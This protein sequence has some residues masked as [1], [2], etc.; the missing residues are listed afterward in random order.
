MTTLNRRAPLLA[1][2]VAAHA[3]CS[4]P[5]TGGHATPA[6]RSTR[7]VEGPQGPLYVDDGGAGGTAVLLVHSGA[8]STEHWAAQLAHLRRDRRAVALDVRGHGRSAPPRDGS[9][10]VPA[11]GEDVVAVADALG[12]RRFVLVGH[13]QGAAV[14]IAAAARAWERVLGLLLLDPATDGR[15]MPR[16]QAAG[17]LAALRSDAYPQL[18]EAYWREQLVGARPVV[19][20][21]VVA[22]LHATRREA[23]IGSL[24]ALLAFDPVTPLRG[25]AF[26]RR[27]VITRINER[28]DALH[29]LVPEISVERIE[30][31]GHWLQLD[32]PEAVNAALDRFLAAITA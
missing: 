31:T 22:D 15:A 2:A 3:A 27:S 30:G 12:I 13:S 7:L 29:A 1:A 16:D 11:M 24:E 28:P 26:P 20:S 23:V 21:R 25:F 4:H 14:A 19:A 18:T 8:G 9:Y 17:L 10:A 6:G 5:H 32:A